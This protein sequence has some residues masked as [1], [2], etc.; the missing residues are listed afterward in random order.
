MVSSLSGLKT[1]A[2]ESHFDEATRALIAREFAH[3]DG[4][5]YLNTC[6]SS[7]PPARVLA[8]YS[9]EMQSFVASMGN[10]SDEPN[11]REQVRTRLAKL[12]GA[13]ADEVAFTHN[14][15]SAIDV[16]AHGW[17]WE[18]GDE[19]VLYD[20]E[21][22]AN[23][24][25]WLL[26][27]R[28]GRIKVR[29]VQ[30]SPGGLKA[31]DVIQAINEKTRAVSVSWV[32][33][34]NG[35][36]VDLEKIGAA[37][38]EAGALFIVDGIQGLGRLT[39][40][41]ESAGI[42]FLASSCHK[43]MLVRGGIGFLYCRREILEKVAPHTG[44]WQS[45]DDTLWARPE[46]AWR[47]GARRFEAGSLGYPGIYALDSALALLEEVG[48]D[49]IEAEIMRLYALLLETLGEDAGVI[50]PVGDL[51]SGTFLVPFAA[52]SHDKAATLLAE[53]KIHGTMRKDHVRLS[54]SFFNTDEQ[55]VNLAGV[56]REL[57][58]I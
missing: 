46:I 16:I 48:P 58:A 37:C 7:V 6:L 22:P 45:I 57:Q 11:V 29:R 56:V 10:K 30:A 39:L 17:S 40:D 49:K 13:S 51:P 25:P 43:G 3:L 12:I 41:V 31:D 33:Y 36:R 21:H 20:R 8:A 28:E 34:S 24:L 35:A 2:S 50:K 55:M 14:T 47:E 27:E 52:E 32:Q 19:V 1:M 18:E 54:I 42:D 9:E 53:K 23:H 4:N 26:R 15:T 44:S 38:R 5:L